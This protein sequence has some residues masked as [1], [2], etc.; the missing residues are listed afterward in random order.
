M[1]PEYREALESQHKILVVLWS[2]FLAGIFLYLWI[3]K[4]FL[5]QWQLAAS[6]A[7]AQAARLVLWLLTLFDLA[8]LVWWKK[9]FLAEEAILGGAKQYKILQSL[10]EHKSPVEERAAAAVSSYVTG[11]IVAFALVEAVAV[12]G[13]A[14][15]LT[16]RYFLGQYILSAAAGALLIVEFPSR[17]FLERLVQAIEPSS[18]TDETRPG[19]E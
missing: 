19:E 18:T 17:R 10:Q 8:T 4:T 11:K 3:S 13:F 6:G 2:V 14:M 5:A 15:V 1:R 7:F 12:Y 9:R 16:S